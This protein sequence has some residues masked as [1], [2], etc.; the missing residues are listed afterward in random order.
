MRKSATAST[1]TL[2]VPIASPARPGRTRRSRRRQWRCRSC[3]AYTT[4]PTPAVRDATRL[5]AAAVRRAIVDRHQR[6]QA[7]WRRRRRAARGRR[8]S[9]VAPSVRLSQHWTMNACAGD[10]AMRPVQARGDVVHRL[11]V[12]GRAL[13]DVGPVVLHVEDVTERQAAPDRRD[14]VP[15]DEGH[16][17]VLV[18]AHDRR[19]EWSVPRWSCHMSIGASGTPSRVDGTI[20]EYWLHTAD[21]DD[22]GRFGRMRRGQLAH[23]V[24]EP[25]P[26]R[27]GVLLGG[28][29][30]RLGA[31]RPVR[32]ADRCAVGRRPGRPSRSWSRRRFRLPTSSAHSHRPAGRRRDKSRRLKVR[33]T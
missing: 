5:R 8:R 9:A 22:A 4:L 28:S 25:L 21:R 24:D 31:Q 2:V 7:E 29:R 19:S 17:R 33:F 26:R 11:D 27:F 1:S 20:D 18:A 14:A 10:A 12:R 30:S 23:R 32:G 15:F 13:V 6:R 16:E 3:R